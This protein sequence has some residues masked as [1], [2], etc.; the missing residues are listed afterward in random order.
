MSFRCF[1]AFCEDHN[2]CISVGAMQNQSAWVLNVLEANILWKSA[3]IRMFGTNMGMEPACIQILVF[4]LSPDECHDKKCWN[5]HLK[6]MFS[7]SIKPISISFVMRVAFC[8]PCT[9]YSVRVSC[10]EVLWHRHVVGINIITNILVRRKDI[11]CVCK[12]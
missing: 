7:S 2:W 5:S 10:V 3:I 6:E 11:I 1:I 12:V 8:R 9:E 4:R